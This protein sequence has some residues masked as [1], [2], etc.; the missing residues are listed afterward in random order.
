MKHRRYCGPEDVALLQAFN[1]AAVESAGW[2][3]YMHVGDIAH[4]LH[5]VARRSNISD[6]LRIWEDIDG[7]AAWALAWVKD[8][9][10]NVQARPDL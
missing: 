5:N 8:G 3:G 9:W 1:A 10:V 7:V 2:P 4:R 6:V